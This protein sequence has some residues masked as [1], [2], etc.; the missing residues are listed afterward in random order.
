[1]RGLPGSGKSYRA[2]QLGI[3]GVIFSTD[4]YFTSGDEYNFDLE[5]LSIAHEWNQDR[6]IKAIKDGISPIVIDNTNIKAW[7]SKPY[8]EVAIENGYDVKIELSGTAW[9]FDIDE[10]VKRNTHRV[11]REVIEKMLFNFKKDISVDDIL[12]SEKPNF[13]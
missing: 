6:A 1:M 7:E 10:L 8:V 4:D 3:S 5:K 11:S 9:E 2:K 13:N 12:K